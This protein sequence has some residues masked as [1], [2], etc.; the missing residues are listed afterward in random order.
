M[1]GKSLI[2]LLLSGMIAC[3]APL[4]F[5]EQHAKTPLDYH[6]KKNQEPTPKRTHH[7]VIPTKRLTHIFENLYYHPEPLNEKNKK[8]GD[9]KEYKEKLKSFAAIHF[10]DNVQIGLDRIKAGPSS[11]HI[12][13]EIVDVNS[14]LAPR[15]AGTTSRGFGLQMKVKLD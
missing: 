2:V 4:C 1:T 13:S 3:V 11:K 6:H 5:A 7:V 12:K 8:Y 9:W 10:T 14:H 15:M